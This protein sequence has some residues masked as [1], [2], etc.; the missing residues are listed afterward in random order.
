M[1][2]L[3]YHITRSCW[4]SF[5]GLA[6]Q[7]KSMEVNAITVRVEVQSEFVL[8]FSRVRKRNFKIIAFQLNSI[9]VAWSS[10]LL[11]MLILENG[12]WRTHISQRIGTQAYRFKIHISK[13]FY[14]SQCLKKRVRIK[15]KQ[16]FTQAMK[17]TVIS[18]ISSLPH[19]VTPSLC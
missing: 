9:G 17:A 13:A 16:L 10:I 7:C 18:S 2:N 6:P 5:R 4:R 1:T 3:S 15:T 14:N 11:K 12:L 8:I 19:S